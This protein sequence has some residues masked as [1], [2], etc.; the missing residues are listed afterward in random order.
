MKSA[1][2]QEEDKCALLWI[3]IGAVMLAGFVYGMIKLIQ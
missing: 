1:V 3:I 2:S